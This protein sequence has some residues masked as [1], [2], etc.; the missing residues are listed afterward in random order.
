MKPGTATAK[1]K[2]KGAH[3][4]IGISSNPIVEPK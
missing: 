1:V 2:E 4:F 3:S